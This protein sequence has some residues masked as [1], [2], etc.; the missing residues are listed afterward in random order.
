MLKSMYRMV[1]IHFFHY[2]NRLLQYSLLPLLLFSEFSAS[3]SLFINLYP[4]A[5]TLC[6]AMNNFALQ[7]T[8][9][10]WYPKNNFLFSASALQLST[11]SDTTLC[12]HSCS[13]TNRS[14]PLRSGIRM[15]TRQKLAH[16]GTIN[17][18]VL[19]GN[20]DNFINV[21]KSINIS[22]FKNCIMF[23]STTV[24]STGYWHRKCKPSTAN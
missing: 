16:P 3:A 21:C 2:A 20:R 23:N 24:V 1:Q 17:G 18:T 10:R 6:L 14:T 19:G 12:V 5:T 11:V 15:W 9:N 13:I 8:L 7:F 22:K 4:L